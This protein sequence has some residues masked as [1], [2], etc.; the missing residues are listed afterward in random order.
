V[1]LV[2]RDLTSRADQHVRKVLL[3]KDQLGC[4]IEGLCLGPK[5]RRGTHALVAVADNGAIGT[6]NQLIGFTLETADNSM[7]MPMMIG[8]AAIA[9]V[10]LGLVMYRLAR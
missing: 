5:L 7:P 1:S 3:W 4:N 10:V 9:A 2:D 6:P 8:G